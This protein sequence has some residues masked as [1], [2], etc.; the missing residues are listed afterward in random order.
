V[1]KV[2]ICYLDNIKRLFCKEVYTVAYFLVYPCSIIK[3][4]S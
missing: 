1:Y 2:F 3:R 4:S